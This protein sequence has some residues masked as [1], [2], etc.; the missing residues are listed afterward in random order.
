VVGDFAEEARTGLVRAVVFE[1]EVV[2]VVSDD[3]FTQAEI[4][5]ILDFLDDE[6]ADYKQF[7][8]KTYGGEGFS[9]TFILSLE[10]VHAYGDM[11][12]RLLSRYPG[13]VLFFEGWGALSLVGEGINDS[14]K[15]VKTT[16][17]VLLD[18]GIRLHDV[19]TSRFRISA[20]VERDRIDEAVRACHEAFIAARK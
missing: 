7:D 17:S 9:F 5:D 6:G 2:Y 15:N 4:R 8:L 10:N 18:R 11:K 12:G 1:R 20:L 14:G 19:H 16:L 3:L 13:R